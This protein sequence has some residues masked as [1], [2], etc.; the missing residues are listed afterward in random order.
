MEIEKLLGNIYYR[1]K[2]LVVLRCC[3]DHIPLSQIDKDVMQAMFSKT[4]SAVN[5][6]LFF[7]INLSEFFYF[8]YGYKLVIH[9]NTVSYK[10]F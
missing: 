2:I 6:P 1:L 3:I 9:R 8:C 5:I 7:K 10:N 4:V